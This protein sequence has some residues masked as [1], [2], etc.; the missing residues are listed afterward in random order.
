[1]SRARVCVLVCVCVCPCVAVHADPDAAKLW[2]VTAGQDSRLQVYDLH[3]KA[4]VQTLDKHVNAVS[5]ISFSPC[6]AYV[7][8]PTDHPC[9]TPPPLPAFSPTKL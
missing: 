6:G 1:V 9:A 5:C 7:R 3:K 4:K 2:L 8:H